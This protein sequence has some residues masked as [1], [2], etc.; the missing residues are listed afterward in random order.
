MSTTLPH[1]S[2]LFLSHGGGPL[3]VLGDPGHEE[4]RENLALIATLMAKPRAIVVVSAHWEENQ[5]TVLSNAAPE[6]FYDYYG[7]PEASY[8]LQYP[9][10]GA[11]ELAQALISR[12]QQ[13]GLDARADSARG[14]DHGLFI[15]L[16]LMYPDAD[17]PCTQLSLLNTLDA[18]AHLRLGEALRGAP[19][20]GTLLI[21][22]GFSFHNMRAFFAPATAET[23]RMNEDFER[24]LVQT[25][26]STELSEVERRQRLQEWTQAPSARYC[27]PR[28]EH[29]LPLH[30]CYGFAGKASSRHFGMSILGK[31]ASAF[32]WLADQ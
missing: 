21:G 26:T 29:L 4:M 22:S 32:L 18:N 31:Q 27:H 11:P 23:R 20:E 6:L 30:V 14:F 12:L 1:A 13:H 16:M 8:A 24:W 5:P 10:P 7:F 9:A 19:P 3:P 25:C 28:E 15:P 2:A 17:I